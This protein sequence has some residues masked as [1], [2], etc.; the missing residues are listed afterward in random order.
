MGEIRTRVERGKG[1]GGCRPVK[2]PNP[3]QGQV[4]SSSRYGYASLL[5]IAAP[6]SD[7]STLGRLSR[8]PTRLETSCSATSAAPPNLATGILFS[9]VSLTPVHADVLDLKAGVAAVK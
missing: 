7:P 3:R 9:L 1:T 2:P 5:D 4:A 8:P 6:P